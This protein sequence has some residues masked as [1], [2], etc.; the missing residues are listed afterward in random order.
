MGIGDAPG[1]LKWFRDQVIW[2][3]TNVI[4]WGP[5]EVPLAGPLRLLVDPRR[6]YEKA[7]V[8]GGVARFG[9]V[10]VHNMAP[11]AARDCRGTLLFVDR[12]TPEGYQRIKEFRRPQRLR[13]ANVEPD[14]WAPLEIPARSNRER[15]DVFYTLEGDQ[16][17]HLATPRGRIGVQTDFPPGAYRVVVRVEGRGVLPTTE[18]F[19]IEHDGPWESAVIRPEVVQAPPA[20]AVARRLDV[21]DQSPTDVSSTVP[22]PGAR[23]QLESDDTRRVSDPAKDDAGGDRLA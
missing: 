1:F 5:A 6:T 21:S 17:L 7:S 15:L 22:G 10:I 18:T 11:V 23:I 20:D 12:L 19:V 14:P 2:F 4:R 8:Q 13:W 3:R 9:H 16:T